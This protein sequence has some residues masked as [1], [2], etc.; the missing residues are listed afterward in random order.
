MNEIT[1]IP[2][3]MQVVVLWIVVEYRAVVVPAYIRA[4]VR[5]GIHIL[6]VQRLE[7]QSL[8]RDIN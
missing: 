2:V 3:E 4:V 1:I 5:L 8:K 6:E 7:G